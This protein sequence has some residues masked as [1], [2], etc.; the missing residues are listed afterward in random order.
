M[1]RPSPRNRWIALSLLLL[2]LA[3]IAPQAPSRGQRLDLSE[4]NIAVVN[5]TGRPLDMVVQP[6][7]GPAHAHPDPD[8]GMD[9]PLGNG[10]FMV[11][12][13]DCTYDVVTISVRWSDTTDPDD[14]IT[15]E[16]EVPPRGQLGIWCLGDCPQPN[17]RETVI[18]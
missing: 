8:I 9:S 18:R 3:L 4:C 10:E 2:A 13:V 17:E 16:L 15:R 14:I 12:P 6:E 5:L 11:E 1:M 7:F